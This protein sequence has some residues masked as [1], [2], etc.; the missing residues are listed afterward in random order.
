MIHF[1]SKKATNQFTGL[2]GM[3]FKKSSK[4]RPMKFRAL[5]SQK[6]RRK[7]KRTKRRAKKRVAMRRKSLRKRRNQTQP[8]TQWS[9]A[10]WI[11]VIKLKIGITVNN[12]EN[13]FRTFIW[14]VLYKFYR[15][16][17]EKV[18]QKVIWLF[19]LAFGSLFYLQIKVHKS[20]FNWCDDCT[21]VE[22]F[23]SK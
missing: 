13:V 8:S 15:I 9:W 18:S 10:G 5:K 6:R 1:Q 21:L 3:T 12:Y 2:K 19:L 11:I 4:F 16:S 20:V 17:H 23:S 14:N 22:N 7:R